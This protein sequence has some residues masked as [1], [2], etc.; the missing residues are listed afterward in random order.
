M[1]C[2]NDVTKAMIS[3]Q[4]EVCPMSCAA[5]AMARLHFSAPYPVGRILKY[6]SPSAFDARPQ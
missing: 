6:A 3:K 5:P 1:M 2:S 4:K